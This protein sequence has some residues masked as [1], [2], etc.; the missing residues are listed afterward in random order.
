MTDDS[1]I[2]VVAGVTNGQIQNTAL[3]KVDADGVH[4]LVLDVKMDGGKTVELAA[5]LAGFGQRL[6]ETWLYQWRLS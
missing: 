1:Q 6:S 5:H 3:F 4:R 2:Q